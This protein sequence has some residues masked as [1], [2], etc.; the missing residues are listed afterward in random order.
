[1]KEIMKMLNFM[2]GLHLHKSCFVFCEFSG[3]FF[4][5][6]LWNLELL[7]AILCICFNGKLCRSTPIS[8][9]IPSN[10]KTHFHFN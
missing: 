1:M 3:F 9:N 5:H 2:V 10:F 6:L 4:S 8:K 7:C